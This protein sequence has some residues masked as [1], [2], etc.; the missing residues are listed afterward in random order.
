MLDRRLRRED[1]ITISRCND[2][3]ESLVE[4][5][6]SSFHTVAQEFNL[7]KENASTNSAFIDEIQLKHEIQN[8]LILYIAKENMTN[9]GCIG[10]RCS[11]DQKI[12][13]IEKLA[14]VPNKRHFG[15]GSKLLQFAIGEILV[16]KAQKISIGIIDE[17][18]ELKEWYK[19][20][21]FY[22]YKINHYNHLPFTVCLMYKDL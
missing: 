11:K 10:I 5:L 13:Y 16:K 15:T 4:V 14:V 12:W 18:T 22:E 3:I 2:E 9:I 1:K 17:N 19:S 20:H 21:G 8:G 6:H 7:T